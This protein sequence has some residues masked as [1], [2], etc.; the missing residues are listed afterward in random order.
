MSKLR[1][2]LGRSTSVA[3]GVDDAEILKDVIRRTQ[4]TLYEDFDW[5]FLRE[6]FPA[7]TLN[8]GQRYYDIPAAFNY[9]RIEDA[10]IRISGRPVPFYRGI[11]FENY[12]TFDSDA[13]VRAA[14]AQRWDIRW[15]GTK[16]QIEIW[17]IPVDSSNAMQF[18][19][20][21]KLRDLT[22]DDD[23]TD[24]DDN[25]IVLF[26]AA[27]LLARQKSEDA[28]IK[29]KA[30]QQLYSRLKGR[31]AAARSGFRLS[32]GAPTLRPYR[33]TVAISGR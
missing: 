16:E 30:G 25:L 8:A 15:T 22:A 27:E 7:I 1:A 28:N 10:A 9:D 5:P 4:E 18:K 26:S 2:E 23:V 31:S 24:L 6:M 20:I 13:G 21:R 19:G 14:P 33:A 32:M 3:V 11:D 17:P 29:L 12:T